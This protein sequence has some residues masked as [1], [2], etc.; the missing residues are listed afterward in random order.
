[1]VIMGYKQ[2]V[3]LLYGLSLEPY[4]SY[5]TSIITNEYIL[6]LLVNGIINNQ[7]K[8]IRH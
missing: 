2:E 4:L 1:M 8:Y 7:N 5:E 3:M 6:V